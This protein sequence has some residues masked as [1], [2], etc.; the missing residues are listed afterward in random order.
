MK[1]A[2]L[3]VGVLA[4]VAAC[5]GPAGGGS[6]TGIPAGQPA[7]APVVAPNHPIGVPP[8]QGGAIAPGQA[9]QRHNAGAVPQPTA[10]PGSGTG[11]AERD[12][13]PPCFGSGNPPLHKLC[14]VGGPAAP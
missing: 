3:A 7:R 6:G 8:V 1:R 13:L 4:L 11:P 2:I 14:P 12:G 9:P 10:Q 5:G